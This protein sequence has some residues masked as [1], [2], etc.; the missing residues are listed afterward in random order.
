MIEPAVQVDPTKFGTAR[1]ASRRDFGDGLWVMRLT[2]DF[3]LGYRPGQYCTLALPLGGRLIERP[4]SICS[5]P[6]ED[7]IELFIERVPEG[8][9]TVPLHV[10]GVG[11][12]LPVRRRCKGLFLRDAPVEGQAHLFVATVTGIAPFLSCIRTLLRRIDRG[13]WSP[14]GRMVLLHGASVSAEFGYL[15]EMRAL[16]GAHDW[17]EYIPTISRPW[18]DPEWSGER[19]RVEDVVRKHADRL[20]LRPGS[21]TAFICGNP[22]MIDNVK[23]ALIRAGHDSGSVHEEQYWPE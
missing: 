9:L 2:T 12:E 3:E 11:A 7:E 18:L 5:S 14:A 23:G 19:G 13:E 8:E 4:Y 20:E 17:F 1:I 6:E 21:A 10:L 15:D 22:Q 16:A